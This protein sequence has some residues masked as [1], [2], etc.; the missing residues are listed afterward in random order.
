MFSR[1]QRFCVFEYPSPVT[2]IA[3]VFVEAPGA[4]VELI[5]ADMLANA[6]RVDPDWLLSTDA[7]APPAEEEAAVGEA[8]MSGNMHLFIDGMAPLMDF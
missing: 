5:W 7:H 2:A 1:A 8:D 4:A 3:R 6:R